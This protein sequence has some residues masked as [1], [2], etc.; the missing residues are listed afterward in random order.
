[1]LAKVRASLEDD[2]A[3]EIAVIDLEGKSSIADFMVVA[4]GRSQR[5]VGAIAEHLVERMEKEGLRGIRRQG[6]P[7]N[8]WVLIDLGDV[9]VHVFRPEVRDYYRLEKMWA[10]DLPPEEA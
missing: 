1:L 5:Q 9:V 10:G 6:M 4:S 7:Q 8:D 2:K 3:E